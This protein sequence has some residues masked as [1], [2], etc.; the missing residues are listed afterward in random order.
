[1]KSVLVGN[2]W[3]DGFGLRIAEKAVVCDAIGTCSAYSRMTWDAS[4]V[5]VI[6]SSALSPGFSVSMY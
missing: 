3:V 4:G 5:L 1:M 2:R 6:S